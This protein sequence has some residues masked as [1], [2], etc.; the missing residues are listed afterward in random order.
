MLEGAARHSLRLRKLA[1]N[2]EK[3]G[4]AVYAAADMIRVEARHS[5]TSGSTSGRGHVPSL[6]G[7]PPNAD[8]HHLDSNI[9]TEK[10][11][12]LTAVVRSNANYAAALEFGTGK[13]AER[14][15]MRPAVKKAEQKIKGLVST[16]VKRMVKES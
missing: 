15:Y 4:A 10:T 16:T 3:M 2:A 1:Q 14:P 9:T 11:G 12:P 7:E 8:T 6:P 5:I 13:M